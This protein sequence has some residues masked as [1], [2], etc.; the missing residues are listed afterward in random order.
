MVGQEPECDDETILAFI[1]ASQITG[2]KRQ[3]AAKKGYMLI[4]FLMTKTYGTFFLIPE[5]LIKVVEQI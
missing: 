5:T 3:V 4:H 1:R 2:C